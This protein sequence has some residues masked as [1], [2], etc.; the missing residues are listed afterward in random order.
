VLVNNAGCGSYGAVED[1]PMDDACAQFDVDVSGAARLIQLALPHMRA[2]RSG[3]IV[4]IT[5]MGS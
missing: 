2:L 1:V 5:S 3:I 4:N